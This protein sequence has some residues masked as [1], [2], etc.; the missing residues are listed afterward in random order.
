[1]GRI[2]IVEDEEDVRELIALHLRRE[3]HQVSTFGEGAEAILALARDPFDLAIVDWMLPDLSGLEICR[4][5]A[6][7]CPVLMVTARVHPQDIVQGL[8]AGADDYVTKPFELGVLMAR[9]RALLRRARRGTKTGLGKDIFEMGALRVD[10]NARLAWCYGRE[11]ELTPSEF[12]LLLAFVQNEGRALSRK[13]LIEVVHGP[14]IAVVDRAIDT[15][16]FCLRT[17]L[18]PAGGSIETVRGVGYR[19]RPVESE[20]HVGV[21]L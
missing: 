7:R 5:V 2:L 14:G 3:G 13:K 11:L 1:M 6:G 4:V 21:H 19:A 20:P 16:V 10:V 12:K 15:L 18:G 17:K 9:V 8:E